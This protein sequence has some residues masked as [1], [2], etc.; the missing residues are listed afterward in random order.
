MATQLDPELADYATQA[1]CAQYV[2]RG[3][4]VANTDYRLG[5]N[6]TIYRARKSC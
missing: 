5:W 4:V 2:H 1:F 3:Y 6:P